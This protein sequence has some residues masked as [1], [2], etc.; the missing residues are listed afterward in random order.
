[1]AWVFSCQS[2]E[3]THSLPSNDL[4]PIREGRN[5]GSGYWWNLRLAVFLQLES[6]LQQAVVLGH[7]F[8][9]DRRE[10]IWPP[11]VS[12]SPPNRTWRR[13]PVPGSPACTPA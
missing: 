2:D 1:M 10:K 4:G 11:T 7:P 12:T 5:D 9:S 6:D 13:V 8:A 3:K